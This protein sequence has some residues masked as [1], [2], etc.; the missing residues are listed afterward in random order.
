MRTEVDVSLADPD[1]SVEELRRMG[2][3][4]RETV[5]RCERL[6]EGLLML[7]RSE[8]ATGREEPADLAALAAD[9]I[10]DLRARAEEA[11]VEVRD[12][13]EPAWTRGDPAL[14]ER[15]IANLRRQRHPPQRAGRVPARSRRAPRPGACCVTVANGGPR[16]DPA[17]ADTLTEPFRRLDRG[18]GGFG[19][20]LSIV[21][22]VVVAHGGT[23]EIR[24]PETG[25]LEVQDRVAGAPAGERHGRYLRGPQERLRR[26][27]TRRRYNAEASCPPLCHTPSRG[28]PAL[29]RQRIATPM[30]T[31]RDRPSR[32]WLLY[33]LGVVAIAVAALAVSE[34]GPPTS[35]ARTSKEIVTAEQGVVQSTVTGSGNIAAGTDVTVNFNT[36]G[37]LQDVYVKVGQHVKGG[38]LLADLDPTSANLQLS[39]GPVAAH[40]RRRTS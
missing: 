5:D 19:L 17:D 13:L 22:S 21:R 38:Q 15:M 30:N 14:L 10:T 18:A 26:A 31:R 25:G 11:D 40:R 23:I 36:S 12:D 24:A 9:C 35:S 20:G 8:A 28:L 1:A 34:I 6:I 37:T 7:A 29:S 32:P 2:D 16:I 4:V 3:A 33:A 39:P 27:D